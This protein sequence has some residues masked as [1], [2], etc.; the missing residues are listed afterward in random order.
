VAL[1]SG[2]HL[3]DEFKQ[4]NRFQKVPCIIEDDGLKLSESV[5]IFRY[6]MTKNTGIDEHWYPKD[7]QSRA[8]V[9]EYLEWQHNNTRMGC[10]MYFQAKWLLPL[11]TGKPTSESKIVMAQTHMENVLDL[12]ENVWLQSNEKDFLT[13]KEISFADILAACELEQPRIADYNPFEGRPRLTKW[14]QKVKEI[15]NPY[16]DQAHAI[17]NKIVT[18]N[19]NKKSKL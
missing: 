16:Y 14:Y 5:A 7:I 3:A 9:D 18:S 10:A 17:L 12:L 1:R 4:I 13:S 11:M 19:D 2:E 8:H 6:L 15:T